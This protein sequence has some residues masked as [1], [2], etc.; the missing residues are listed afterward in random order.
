M[1]YGTRWSSTGARR[2]FG[3]R[4]LYTRPNSETLRMCGW[5]IRLSCLLSTAFFR[6]TAVHREPG[7]RMLLDAH[8]CRTSARSH[9]TRFPL[10]LVLFDRTTSSLIVKSDQQLR[11]HKDERQRLPL[12][13][14]SVSSTHLFGTHL[15][16]W[17]APPLPASMS[18]MLLRVDTSSNTL[19]H[20]LNISQHHLRPSRTL[21]T[22][23]IERESTS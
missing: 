3:G 13:F 21:S 15:K 16:H 8:D 2:H 5:V 18:D 12:L 19:F 20:P 6:T 1:I 17:I 9:R 14:A 4:C 23:T 11:A 10:L 7:L 22:P